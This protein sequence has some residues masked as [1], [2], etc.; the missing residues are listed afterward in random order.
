MKPQLASLAVSHY[1]LY[2]QHL[3]SRW[4]VGC[5][6]CVALIGHW[7]LGP[8]QKV[9]GGGHGSGGTLKGPGPKKPR[10]GNYGGEV[11]DP[12]VCRPGLGQGDPAPG[13]GQGICTRGRADSKIKKKR[14]VGRR[15]YP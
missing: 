12:S 5:A 13:S 8:T 10:M 7:D 6:A 14:D 9:Q 15:G 2:C 1:Q 3:Q 4:G 11:S